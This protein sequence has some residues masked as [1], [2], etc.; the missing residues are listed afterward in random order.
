MG[1]GRAMGEVRQ[2]LPKPGLGRGTMRSIM[3]VKAR[4]FPVARF[5]LHRP[6]GGPLPRDKLGEEL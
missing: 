1:G 4:N 2:I 6:S 5:P 3:E